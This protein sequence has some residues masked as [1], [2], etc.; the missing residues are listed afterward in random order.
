MKVITSFTLNWDLEVVAEDSHEYVGPITECKGGGAGQV[1]YQGLEDLYQIQAD[2]ASDLRGV[3]RDTVIPG[4][5]RLV[6]EARGYGSQANQEEQAR[7]AGAS[8]SAATGAALAGLTDEMKSMG[9]DPTQQKYASSYAQLAGQGAANRAASETNA[10]DNVRNVGFGREQDVIALG[11]GTPTQA[12]SAAQ[13]ASQS[14]NAYNNSIQQA[15][16]QQ[17]QGIGNMVRGGMDLYGYLNAKDGG[18][19]SRKKYATGGIVRMGQPTQVQQPPSQMHTPSPG[20]GQ[21]MSA[22]A[23]YMPAMGKGVKWAGGKMGNETMQTVGTEMMKP[24]SSVWA[25]QGGTAAKYGTTPGSQQT[26]QLA[27]QEGGMNS[28]MANYWEM[29]KQQINN[30]LPKVSGMETLPAAEGTAT[31]IGAEAAGAAAAETAGAAAAEIAAAEAA[32]AAAAEVGTAATVAETVGT[33]ALALLKDGG[34]ARGIHADAT[35]GGEVDGPGG[36]KD[37]MIPA[38]LSDGEYVLPIGTVK[39]YGLAK[40]EKMRQEGLQFEEE[41]GI[42][43]RKGYADGGRVEESGSAR[44]RRW[45]SETYERTRD[46]LRNDVDDGDTRSKHMYTS[47]AGATVNTGNAT[48]AYL[49]WEL[50]DQPGRVKER[51]QRGVKR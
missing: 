4:Y 28:G 31:A 7:R 24:G 32:A 15:S 49:P 14:L 22:G 11:M 20:V 10:R 51:A 35:H 40:L 23:K 13:G 46:K 2:T 6:D 34:Q 21:I 45:M 39:K 48:L 3:A 30:M 5:R 1:R 29:A 25:Q 36:P 18:Y 8:S 16:A 42:R 9:I 44:N 37:D 33:A 47:N 26:A 41:L 43:P 38:M 12:A 17:A 19:I 27:A 50:E